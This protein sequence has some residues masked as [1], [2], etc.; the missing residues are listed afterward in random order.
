MSST[1]AWSLP[2]A[3]GLPHDDS[4]CPQHQLP[5]WKRLCLP[6]CSW[7]CQSQHSQDH[8]QQQVQCPTQTTE[9]FD[10][11]HLAHELA[12]VQ[13][14]EGVSCPPESRPTCGTVASG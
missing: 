11:P 1:V 13:A 12:W 8:P 9:V 5:T 7:L 2:V 4:A 3:A 6:W 10:L 14:E